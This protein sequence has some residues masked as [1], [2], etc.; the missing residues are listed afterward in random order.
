MGNCWGLGV[1]LPWW[2]A[3]WL[4]HQHSCSFEYVSLLPLSLITGKKQN[5]EVTSNTRRM[6]MFMLHYSSPANIMS[7]CNLHWHVK[8]LYFWLF[9]IFV[10]SGPETVSSEHWYLFLGIKTKLGCSHIQ[11]LSAN[12]FNPML[13]TSLFFCLQLV[14]DN[15]CFLVLW[16]HNHHLL[17]VTAVTS[18]TSK[19]W[20][21]WTYQISCLLSCLINFL[22]SL[23]CLM[24]IQ[25]HFFA[26][27]MKW[28]NLHIKS[29]WTLFCTCWC[30]KYV[31]LQHQITNSP[32]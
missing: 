27:Q 21:S 10:S 8:S 12:Y 3:E 30:W 4:M 5:T 26:Y 16:C 20:W 25:N 14:I 22:L 9:F 32:S 7:L 11:W 18:G 31:P 1:I 23:F 29:K 15:I 19:G 24:W 17:H 2:T 13:K 6:L 28:N